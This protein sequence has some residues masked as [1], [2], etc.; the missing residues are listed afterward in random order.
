MQASEGP[1]KPDCGQDTSK[2]FAHCA[3]DLQKSGMTSHSTAN[4][5]NKS[6]QKARPSLIRKTVIGA[7]ASNKHVASVKTFRHVDIFV[8]RCH[9]HTADAMLTDCVDVS[10]GELQVHGVICK[11][12]KSRYE[13]LYSS[14]HVQVKVASSDFKKAIDLFMSA[15][16]W[17]SDLLVR[18]YFQPKDGEK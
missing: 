2:S 17:P 12:L 16:A 8:S 7:S 4:L 13:H 15:E 5:E 11:K 9:P 18:R 10:K 1:N 14:F 3:V 6:K